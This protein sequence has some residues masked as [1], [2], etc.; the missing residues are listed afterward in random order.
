MLL[1]ARWK[2]PIDQ[3]RSW[4]SRKI[5]EE[6][7]EQVRWKLGEENNIFDAMRCDIIVIITIVS[8]LVES[9]SNI[10]TEFF[11]QV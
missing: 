2:S 6:T 11:L 7:L 8:S 5:L 10:L 4:N 3:T 9:E 1:G